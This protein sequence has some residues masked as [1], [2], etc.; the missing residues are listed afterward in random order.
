MVELTMLVAV[1]LICLLYFVSGIFVDDI[2]LPTAFI[3][4]V[5]FLGWGMCGILIP[6][7]TTTLEVKPDTV[8]ISSC[9]AI[10]QYDGNQIETFTNVADYN[11]IKSG[12]CKFELRTVYD[13]Y[14]I[15]ENHFEVKK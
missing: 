6:V 13:L 8:F 9:A 12:T 2:M 1:S 14:G 3:I 10:V 15:R 5:G 11:K 7:Q 4:L